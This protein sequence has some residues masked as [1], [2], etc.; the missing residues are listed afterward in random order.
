MKMQIIY[1]EWNVYMIELIQVLRWQLKKKIINKEENK[2]K[3]KKDI[4]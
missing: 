3:I 4:L 2:L 1:I